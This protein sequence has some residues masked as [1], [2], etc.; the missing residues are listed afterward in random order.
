MLLLI[1]YFFY[2][3]DVTLQHMNLTESEFD[4]IVAE[5]LRFARQRKQRE[6]KEKENERHNENEEDQRINE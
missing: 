6:D 2:F 1:K 3:L 4:N 5:W